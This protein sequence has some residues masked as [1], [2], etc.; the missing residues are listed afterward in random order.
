MTRRGLPGSY[1]TAS[2]QP[3]ASA[4]DSAGAQRNGEDRGL[5]AP[6][7]AGLSEE[8]RALLEQL[9]DR[10]DAAQAVFMALSRAEHAATAA[11]EVCRV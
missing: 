4:A 11:A 2:W 5:R 1:P 6:V 9:K 3:P 8:E 10:K 7:T